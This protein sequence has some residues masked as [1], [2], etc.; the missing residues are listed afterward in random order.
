MPREDLKGCNEPAGSE[1]PL[2]SLTASDGGKPDLSYHSLAS[3]LPGMQHSPFQG[4][5]LTCE[6]LLLAW[7]HLLLG[8]WAG[9]THKGL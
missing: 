7:A 4:L 3:F 8:W 6:L 2:S 1:P 9:L 5:R